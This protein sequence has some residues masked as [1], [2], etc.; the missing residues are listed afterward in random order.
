[1][2]LNFNLNTFL[3]DKKARIIFITIICAIV[4]TLIYLSTN[5]KHN[6]LPLDIETNIPEEKKIT[7]ERNDVKIE[8]VNGDVLTDSA[9]KNVYK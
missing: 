6:K 2:P 3:K 1:M 7:N 8:T 9:T 4:V 5:G